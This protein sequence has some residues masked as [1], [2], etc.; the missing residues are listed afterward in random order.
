ML[1]V[2]ST[3]V[4]VGAVQTAGRGGSITLPANE[5]EVAIY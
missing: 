4:A 1:A 3:A 2:S 5:P